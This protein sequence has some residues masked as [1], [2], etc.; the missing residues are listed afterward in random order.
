MNIPI[1]EPFCESVFSHGADEARHNTEQTGNP[2]RNEHV[3]STTHHCPA[4]QSRAHKRTQSQLSKQ[5]ALKKKTNKQTNKQIK[6]KQTKKFN[7]L[8]TKL[9]KLKPKT[10]LNKIK[11]KTQQIRNN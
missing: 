8:K 1:F 2:R 7:K 5:P 9:Y 4:R 3:V 10:K 11:N 6:N